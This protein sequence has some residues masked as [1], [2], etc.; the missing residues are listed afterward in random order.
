MSRDGFEYPLTVN[1]GEDNGWDL[2]RCSILHLNGH[3]THL[4]SSDRGL[5]CLCTLMCVIFSVHG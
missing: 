4:N 3:L 5:K 2:K 1:A